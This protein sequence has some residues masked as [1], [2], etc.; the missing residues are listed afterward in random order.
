M[1]H[2]KKHTKTSPEKPVK[3]YTKLSHFTLKDPRKDP[4]K[5]PLKDTDNKSKA[6]D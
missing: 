2:S 6:G 5:D 3:K 4:L 1:L